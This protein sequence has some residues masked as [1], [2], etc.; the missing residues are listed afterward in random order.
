ML[1]KTT[2]QR[3]ESLDALTEPPPPKQTVI[4]QLPTLRAAVIP[5]DYAGNKQKVFAACICNVETMLEFDTDLYSTE[6]NRM[7]FAK[8][9][10]VGNAAAQWDQFRARHP[11]VEY[12]WEVMKNLLYSRVAQT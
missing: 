9:Y 6:R 7:Q 12:N 5:P 8:Q 10:L 1:G 3:R 4:V 2:H 11:E